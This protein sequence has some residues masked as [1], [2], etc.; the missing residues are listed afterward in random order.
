MCCYLPRYSEP[1]RDIHEEGDNNKMVQ[2][3]VLLISEEYRNYEQATKIK[4][5]NFVCYGHR[6][7]SSIA[8]ELIKLK[9]LHLNNISN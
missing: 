3:S 7:P 4:L 6:S 9:Q 2:K 1:I 5:F 8:H